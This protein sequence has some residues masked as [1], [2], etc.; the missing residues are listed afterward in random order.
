MAEEVDYIDGEGMT[1]FLC[2]NWRHEVG[3]YRL[4]C[5]K[6]GHAGK[7]GTHADRAKVVNPAERGI[8]ITRTVRNDQPIG[9]SSRCGLGASGSNGER[10]HIP[11]AEGKALVV[12]IADHPAAIHR[13]RHL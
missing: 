1:A 8:Y 5:R 11:L 9:P 2:Y 13:H 10:R 4:V 6:V 7:P 12:N 3:G